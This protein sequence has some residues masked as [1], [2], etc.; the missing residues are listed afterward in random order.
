VFGFLGRRTQRL[1][2]EELLPFS[3][4]DVLPERKGNELVYYIRL[5]DGE[6]VGVD[7]SQMLHFAGFGFNGVRSL[8]VI[9]HAACN[10][11]GLAMAMEQFSSEFFRS[12]AHQDVALIYKKKLDEPAKHSIRESWAKTY[13]GQG[14]RKY[15]LVLPEGT[16][17][18]ELSI[19]AEDSQLLESRRFQIAE[20]A[21][22][23][24]IPLFLLGETEKSTS[25]GSGLA[26]LGLALVRYTLMPHLNR[27]Q[28]E[29]NRKLF[30]KS[31]RYVEHI[32][33]GLLKG[34][35]KERFEAYKVALGGSNVPGWMTPNE[36]RRLENR[37]PLAGRDETY[38]PP[39]GNQHNS[40]SGE[41]NAAK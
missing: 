4:L 27:F 22:A 31:D 19:N 1:E 16:E 18:K 14:K 37:A 7:Q 17:L 33:E 5:H 2:V 21:R 39:A 8:S 35:T 3:P 13:A 24:G 28:Q 11:I 32:L 25:W 29:I 12:G 30:L 15:P 6:Y 9:K 26:E 40:P 38:W 10:S 20:I 36:V 23:F 34:T 41:N